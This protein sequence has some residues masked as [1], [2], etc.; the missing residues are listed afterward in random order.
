MKKE[1]LPR[2]E[3]ITR[4]PFP[5]SK[6]VFVK[7]EIHNINVAMRTVLGSMTVPR[8]EFNTASRSPKIPLILGL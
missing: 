8:C 2:Q 3:Q 5:A 4:T 7:G 1:K 6:K